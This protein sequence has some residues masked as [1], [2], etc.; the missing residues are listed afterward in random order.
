MTSKKS[1]IPAVIEHWWEMPLPEADGALDYLGDIITI[2]PQK[3][4]MRSSGCEELR[5]RRRK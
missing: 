2:S 5:Y 1:R 4:N 3:G